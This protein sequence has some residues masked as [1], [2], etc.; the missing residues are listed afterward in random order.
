[1]QLFLSLITFLSLC[2]VTLTFRFCFMLFYKMFVYF[3]FSFFLFSSLNI[4]FFVI[5]IFPVCSVF[6]FLC[7]I[8]AAVDEINPAEQAWGFCLNLL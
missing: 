7:V 5:V 3:T 8:V 6:V 1:M 2:P 4:L